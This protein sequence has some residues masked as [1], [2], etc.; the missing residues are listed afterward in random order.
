MSDLFISHTATGLGY[1]ATTT[2][3]KISAAFCRLSELSQH[4]YDYWLSELYDDEG[5]MVVDQWN[6]ETLSMMEDDVMQ[7]LSS[8]DRGIV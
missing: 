1:D 2:N 6:N 4:V 5:A 7:Q 3:D 8:I